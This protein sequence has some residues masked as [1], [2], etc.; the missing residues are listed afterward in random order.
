MRKSIIKCDRCGL[1]RE[2]LPHSVRPDDWTVHVQTNN[3]ICPGCTQGSADLEATIS[4]MREDFFDENL[5]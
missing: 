4:K 3:D 5:R 2:I 1:E